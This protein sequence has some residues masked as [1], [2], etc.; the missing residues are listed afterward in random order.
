MVL[1]DRWHRGIWAVD[2]AVGAALA[3]PDHMRFKTHVDFVISDEDMDALPNPDERDDGD[4][5]AF[6]VYSGK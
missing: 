6:P 2:E 5:S 1:V 4:S 3:N